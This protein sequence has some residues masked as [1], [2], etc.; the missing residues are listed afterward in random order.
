[1]ST[2]DSHVLQEV[3]TCSKV[4]AFIEHVDTMRVHAYFDTALSI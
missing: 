3:E 4:K 2:F 1:M